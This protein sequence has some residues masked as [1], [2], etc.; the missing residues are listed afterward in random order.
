MHLGNLSLTTGRIIVG[1]PVYA[2]EKGYS[3][4]GSKD[5]CFDED[6]TPGDHPVDI[7]LLNSEIAALRITFKVAPAHALHLEPAFTDISRAIAK[8][9]RVLPSVGVDSATAALFSSESLATFRANP[10]YLQGFDYYKLGKDCPW[11]ECRFP[12]GSNA[13]VGLA[14]KGDGSYPAYF[15]KT[16]QRDIVA[17]IVDFRELGKPQKLDF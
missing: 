11:A 14:G 9:Q 1:D 16:S 6:V 12:D 4:F 15:A 10:E 8:Q 7:L 2:Q 17:L 3:D 13:F 5:G